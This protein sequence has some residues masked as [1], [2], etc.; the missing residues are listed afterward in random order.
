MDTIIV[1]PAASITTLVGPTE[2]NETLAVGQG[3]SGPVGPVGPAGPVTVPGGAD[4]QVQYNSAG[5]FAGSANFT[6]DQAA[7]TLTLTGGSVALAGGVVAAS[8]PVLNA[9]Q[10]WNN[11]AITFTGW[12]L[13]V[14]DTASAAG[15]LL[16]DLQ[17]GSV[18]KFSVDKTGIAAAVSMRSTSD[19]YV[20]TSA[21]NQVL[22]FGG[23]AAAQIALARRGG[24]TDTLDVLTGNQVAY[25]KLRADSMTLAVGGLNFGT[26]GDLSLYRDAANTL[27][28]RNGANAQTFRLYNNYTGPSDYERM[29]A[30]WVSNVF[31]MK[32]EG[33]G[34]GATSRGFQIAAGGA[35]GLLDINTTIGS[36]L[37]WSGAF[38]TLDG[39]GVH[40]S[41]NSTVRWNVDTNGHLV[42]SSN[43]N[44][45]TLNSVV[46]SPANIYAQRFYSQPSVGGIGIMMDDSGAAANSYF[47][48]YRFA[49][50][51]FF[52]TS[53][54]GVGVNKNIVLGVG[55]AVSGARLTIPGDGT[56]PYFSQGLRT[57]SYT[58]ATLPSASVAGA[59]TIL[60]VTDATANTYD[61]VLAGGGAVKIGARSDGTNWRAF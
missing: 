7:N 50:D 30:G 2:I 35:L 45:G 42:P 47:A 54:N 23:T 17:V 4:N 5:A 27:A 52:G 18:S 6:Y 10:A 13:N 39:N 56:T 24:S 59:G 61:A 32:A 20:G 33:A 43:Y 53:H 48:A 21:S 25:A 28:Q 58:V 57:T 16:A 38:V 41:T 46:N 26:S 49:S 55:D 29:N 36:R 37:T 44:I 31:V 12:K 51:W 1:P 34:T 22:Y 11:A 60:Y 8:V 3:P 40:L 19:V 14:T 15:S 9:S